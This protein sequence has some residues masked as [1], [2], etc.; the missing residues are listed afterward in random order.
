[1]T[2]SNVNVGGA[3][4]AF[5]GALSNYGGSISLGAT[6]ASYVFN[7]AT[8][9]NPCTG[10]PLTSFDLGTGGSTLS[11]FN[12]GGLVYDLG[13]LAGGANTVL[14]GRMSNSPV[15]PNG[16]TYRIGANGNST[17][18]S[19]RIA[20][21]LD[22]VAVV[23]VGTGTLLLNGINTFSGGTT[24][25]NG[26]LGGTGSIA[27]ALTVASG[28][29]LSPGAPMGTFTVSNNATLNG[30]MLIQLNNGSTP[31]SGT[32]S[33]TGTLTGGGVLTVTNVGPD[34]PNGTRF[35]LFNKAATGF[36]SI[37]IPTN[38]PSNTSTYNWQNNIGVDGSITLIS[39]GSSSV[40]TNPT[41]MTFSVSGG[42]LTVTWPGDH[43][44]WQLQSNP[45]SL[46]TTSWFP[47]AGSTSVTQENM[48]IDHSKTNV[49]FRMVYPPSP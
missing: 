36:S 47:V 1:V 11:N 39:G 46:T 14:A 34:I 41:N 7:N 42:T 10:S 27:G 21:G 24:V 48:T 37:T 18:F 16:S 23:K 12:G 9:K 35:Q 44:G 43:Q 22:N 25:S 17:T 19:G 32:L 28:G 38:N 8:N 4:F 40:N 2:F 15:S 30:A 6:T 26:L 29:T 3:T 49:F 31:N 5:S 20:D 45:V 33:V 13:S